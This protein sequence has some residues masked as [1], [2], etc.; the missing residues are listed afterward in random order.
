V[1]RFSFGLLAASLAVAGLSACNDPSPPADSGKPQASATPAAPP[2]ATSSAETPSK[3]MPQT[4]LAADME[5]SG[6]V[7]DALQ[8]PGRGR[9]EV[10]AS[11]GVVTLY[12]TV[13]QPA[14]K[15]RIALTAM[16]VEGVRSVINNLVVMR[17]S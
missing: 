15:D 10:A 6:K 1:K 8:E 4:K 13:E 3:G 14:D 16:E 9:V 11:D 17:E 12:G 2:P 5:L 7:K